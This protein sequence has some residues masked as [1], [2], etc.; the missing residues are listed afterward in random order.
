MTRPLFRSVAHTLAKLLVLLQDLRCFVLG[1][2]GHENGDRG[3]GTGNIVWHSLARILLTIARNFLIPNGIV[4]KRDA[5]KRVLDAI[6]P[7]PFLH[8]IS[9]SHFESCFG[10]S[11]LATSPAAVKIRDQRGCHDAVSL[12][13]RWCQRYRIMSSI[14][15]MRQRL[16]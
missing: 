1:S 5:P 7:S 9:T 16:I 13:R 3:K 6:S 2:F 14:S 8:A 4:D 11:T 10:Y 15:R 12:R